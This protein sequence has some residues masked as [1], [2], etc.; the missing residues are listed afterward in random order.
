MESLQDRIEEIESRQ[1]A[2]FDADAKAQCGTIVTIGA[3]GEAQL[4]AGLL[5][6]EM[7]PNWRTVAMKRR[8]RRRPRCPPPISRKDIPPS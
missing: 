4:I 1:T 2:T 5:R 7:S 8:R 6:K 3:N